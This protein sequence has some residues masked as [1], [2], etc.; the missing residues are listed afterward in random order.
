MA[1]GLRMDGRAWALLV[2]LSVLWGGSFFFAKVA[3]AELPPLTLVWLRV[4][5]AAA[6][7]LLV[8]R[9]SG[10]SMPASLRGWMPFAAM[11]LIN[12]VVPFGLI[13]WSQPTITSGLRGQKP[14]VTAAGQVTASTVLLLPFA[15]ALEQPWNLA[16]PGARTLG[17]VAGTA[18]LSTAL[19]YV[20]YFKILAIAGATNL[21]LVTLQIPV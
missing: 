4:A 10:A 5:G 3:L 9:L 15:L 6:T 2:A 19:G 1:D 20:I 18:L 8:V 21:L 12:N 11:G 13:T 14:L 7:L 17:A 16:L